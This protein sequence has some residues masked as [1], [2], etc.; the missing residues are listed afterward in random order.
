MQDTCKVR[1][2]DLQE[3]IDSKAFLLCLLK[4][5]PYMLLI[6]LTGAIIGSGLYLLIMVISNRTPVYVQ[7]TE[8]YIDFADGRLEAKDYYNDFTWNDVMA[9]DPILGR[10]MESLGSSYDKDMVKNMITADILSDVR[11]LTIT[12]QGENQEMVE[13]VSEATKNSLEIYG[14]SVD[15]FDAIYQIED[16]GAV[17]KPVKF[18]TWRAV[19]VGFAVAA[20]V[21]FFVFCICFGLGE[22]FYTKSDIVKKMGI[23]AL[24]LLY[25]KDNCKEGT[26]ER[27]TC[28]SLQDAVTKEAVL[29]DVAEGRHAELFLQVYDNIAGSEAVKLEAIDYPIMNNKCY[30]II[31][32]MQGV[33][34]VIPFG[35]PCKNKLT[36]VINELN[37]R[38][39]TILGAVIAQADKKWIKAYYT[40]RNF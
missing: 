14:S 5:I 23:P 30:D 9:T 39:C 20:G 29:L 12:V 10:T 37:R 11:F 36:D 31:K 40:G 34:L 25:A 1:E 2:T 27:Q 24:G 32:N 16:N 38:E 22:T 18:F 17:L 7:E 26:L 13:K 21:A 15:E 8:Y 6:G 35:I 28:L 3:G 33:I 4:R 19:L